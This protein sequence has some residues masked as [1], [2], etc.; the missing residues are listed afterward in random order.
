MQLQE[1]SERWVLQRREQ[2]LLCPLQCLQQ[3]GR[4]DVQSCY[5]AWREE[6]KLVL[7]TEKEGQSVLATEREGQTVLATERE[8]QAL[9]ATEKEGD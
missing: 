5:Q 6:G 3:W 9:L 4:H 2:V 7:E 8:G 1:E